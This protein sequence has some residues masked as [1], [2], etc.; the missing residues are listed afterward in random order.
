MAPGISIY[1]LHGCGSM[2]REVSR[3][4][5]PASTKQ[6]PSV[7]YPGAH[8]QLRALVG[9]GP[10]PS[11]W[12]KYRVTP[13]L[14]AMLTQVPWPQGGASYGDPHRTPIYGGGYLPANSSP[15]NPGQGVMDVA[16]SVS[17]ISKGSEWR[18]G[19]LWPALDR[20]LI[21]MA[22]LCLHGCVSVRGYL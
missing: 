4:S 8:T 14:R 22:T 17:Y 6:L 1:F 12:T 21:S 5:S 7:G 10:D 19:L 20:A 9:N 3:R 16:L 2:V 11:L 18:L 15:G 13:L